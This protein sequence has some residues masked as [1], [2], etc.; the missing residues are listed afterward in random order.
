MGESRNPF[1]AILPWVHS[2]L[3]DGI[4]GW[5][6]S[7]AAIPNGYSLC[8]GTN[9]TP[10]LRDKF[11][12]CADSSY[13]VSAEGGSTTHEHDFTGDGHNHNPKA[14]GDIVDD[15]GKTHTSTTVPITGTADPASS[16][17]TYYALAYLMSTGES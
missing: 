10:D 6:G 9:R 14:S 8:D 15:V 11:V 2:I 7:I 13:V 17:P 16:L 5:S 12:V 3:G 1:A 4:Y